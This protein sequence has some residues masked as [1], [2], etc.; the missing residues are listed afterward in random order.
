LIRD[1]Y[2]LRYSGFIDGFGFNDDNDV[3]RRGNG[4]WLVIAKTW[5]LLIIN[6]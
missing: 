3:P 4:L 1:T 2:D 6:T 5:L